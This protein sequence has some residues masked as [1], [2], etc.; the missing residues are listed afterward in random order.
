MNTILIFFKHNIFKVFK[1]QRHQE[2]FGKEIHSRRKIRHSKATECAG[3]F[4]N[5]L[6]TN[7]THNPFTKY[8]LTLLQLN[9]IHTY[10]FLNLHFISHSRY[11]LMI[12]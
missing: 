1:T 8:K 2:K 9:I 3:T 4:N 7:I 12:Y 6:T 10:M 5:T 11:G